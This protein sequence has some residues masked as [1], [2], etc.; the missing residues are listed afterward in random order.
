MHFRD[1]GE[2]Q[3]GEQKGSVAIPNTASAALTPCHRRRRG[4]KERTLG[5]CPSCRDEVRPDAYS[6]R[7]RDHWYHL[8]CALESESDRSQTAGIT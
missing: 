4:R 1:E 3:V 5:A 2:E 7:Y 8:R 6:V